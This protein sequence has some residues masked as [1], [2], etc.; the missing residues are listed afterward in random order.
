[1]AELEVPK[2]MPSVP[3]E[4]DIMN[5]E[6]LQTGVEDGGLVIEDTP[7]RPGILPPSLAFDWPQ[8]LSRY[9]GASKGLV[10]TC[11]NRKSHNFGEFNES[12]SLHMR[13]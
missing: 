8:E 6:G 7:R 12:M 2:S 5:G 4:E 13:S 10:D 3:A 9:C 11:P 1:M